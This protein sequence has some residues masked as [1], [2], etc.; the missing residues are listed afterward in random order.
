MPDDARYPGRRRDQKV[1]GTWFPWL[2]LG[3]T[4]AGTGCW[5]FP[6]FG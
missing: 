5:K 3:L 6:M 1:M 4:W 2:S